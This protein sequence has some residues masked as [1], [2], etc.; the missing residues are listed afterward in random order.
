MKDKEGIE[1]THVL[2]DYIV[3]MTTQLPVRVRVRLISSHEI[4]SP[5]ILRL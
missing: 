3:I 5:T 4:I 1:I 2:R